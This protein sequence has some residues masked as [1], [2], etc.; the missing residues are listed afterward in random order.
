MQFSIFHILPRLRD[1][2][3]NLFYRPWVLTTPYQRSN[4]NAFYA[5][6]EL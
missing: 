4:S 5:G 3:L 1:Q 2:N 6:L